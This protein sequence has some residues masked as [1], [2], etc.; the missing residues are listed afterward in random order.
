MMLASD[1][2]SK[3]DNIEEILDKFIMSEFER[4]KVFNIDKFQ[5]E[6]L[7]D[8]VLDDMVLDVYDLVINTMSST[9]YN[10]V[11]LIYNKRVLPS[12]IKNKVVMI[13]MNEGVQHNSVIDGESKYGSENVNTILDDFGDS[14]VD[15]N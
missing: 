15:L 6:Y 2:Y 12:I 13:I 8:K 7:T 14:Y 10:T 1:I 3:M 9:L 5:E 11:S 4:Y